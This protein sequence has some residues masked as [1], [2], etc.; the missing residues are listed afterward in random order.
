[1]LGLKFPQDLVYPKT[2]W[3]TT[4]TTLSQLQILVMFCR[5]T[6]DTVL[7]IQ[8][9]RQRLCSIFLTVDALRRHPL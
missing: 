8:T 2:T 9:W 5:D 3:D 7:Q 6:A 1:M 4:N